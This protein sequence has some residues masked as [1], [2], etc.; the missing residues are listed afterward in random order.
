M[1]L[2]KVKKSLYLEKK[3][4]VIIL[5]EI[6]FE[7]ENSIGVNSMIYWTLIGNGSKFAV[8]AVTVSVLTWHLVKR[9][10]KLNV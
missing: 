6:V 3:N 8:N 5:C 1:Y 7:K 9:V 2:I 10:V 4:I